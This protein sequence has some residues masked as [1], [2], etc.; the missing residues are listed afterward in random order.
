MLLLLTIN[1]GG[2]LIE[3]A[4][5]DGTEEG[6]AILLHFCSSLEIFVHAADWAFA[7]LS[8]IQRSRCP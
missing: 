3:S 5:G 4:S 7:T 6:G 1:R 2:E 8:Q